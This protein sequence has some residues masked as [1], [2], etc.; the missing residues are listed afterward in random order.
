MAVGGGVLA[1]CHEDGGRR[2]L[3]DG[4]AVEELPGPLREAVYVAPGSD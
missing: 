4:G 1:G 3:Q 2:V